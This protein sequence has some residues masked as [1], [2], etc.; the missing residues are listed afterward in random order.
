[1]NPLEIRRQILH[2]LYGPLIVLLYHRGILS[3]GLLLAVIVI[4]AATSHMIKR[5]R[6]RPVAWLLSHFER[7]HHMANFPGRG[8][9]FFTIGAYLCL[10]IFETPIAYAGILMLSVGDAVCNLVGRHF[11]RIKTPLNPKK[12]LE[13][14]LLGI[15]ASIPVAYAFVPDPL[16]AVAASAVAMMLELPNIQLFKMEIDDNIVIPLAASLT[17]SLFA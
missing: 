11:G 14:T 3:N 15:L 1:M 8:I 10:L 5:N 2:F 13:G 17:L 6:M 16:A 4:G 7:E 12:Y 9:L